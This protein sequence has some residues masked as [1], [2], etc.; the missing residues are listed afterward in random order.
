M[1]QATKTNVKYKNA[2][3]TAKCSLQ[4]S[5]QIQLTSKAVDGIVTA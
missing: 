2:F 1:A 5:R 4:T 3:S